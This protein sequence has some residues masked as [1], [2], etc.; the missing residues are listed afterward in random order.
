MGEAERGVGARVHGRRHG[1]RVVSA[2]SP[3]SRQ[4][5]AH[6]RRAYYTAATAGTSLN[7]DFM[8]FVT[9]SSL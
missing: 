2:A 3:P 9:G 6:T 8:E 1:G 5:A 4:S 7:T